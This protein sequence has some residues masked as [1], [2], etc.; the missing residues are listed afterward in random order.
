MSYALWVANSRTRFFWCSLVIPAC[1][2]LVKG[3]KQVYSFVEMV[4][5]HNASPRREVLC[6]P[7]CWVV[8]SRSRLN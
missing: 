5:R 3:P 8:A 4:I 6:D 2:S 1:P 7:V